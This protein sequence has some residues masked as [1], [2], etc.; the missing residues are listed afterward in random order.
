[1]RKNMNFTVTRMFPRALIVL[2][3]AGV[4]FPVLLPGQDAAK[5]AKTEGKY[6]GAEKCKN[7]HQ[8]KKA[9]NQ[10]AKWKEMKHARAFE[11]LASDEAKKTAK[12]NGV[13][14][15]QKSPKCLRCHV[16]A[17]DVP[18]ER[19]A[20]GFNQ[21][22]GVQCESCHGP[23]EKHFKARFAAAGEED[24]SEA[25]DHQEIPNE[26]IV[27]RPPLKACLACH[28]QEAPTF[29]NFCLKKRYTEIAHLDP[30]KERSK[31][32]LAA[33]KCGCGEKCEC[34]Q[35][36]CGELEATKGKAKAGE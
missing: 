17:F 27:K 24:A 13:D 28:N 23:G 21:K 7:C 18:A 22:L 34:K 26:E 11:L 8:A 33:M 5:Q 10:F 2:S 12:E 30:R 35:G 4:L 15:P 19:V 16:T 9:G 1:M 3:A 31:E 20:K 36:E 32:E 29:K 25:K 14:D 6:I